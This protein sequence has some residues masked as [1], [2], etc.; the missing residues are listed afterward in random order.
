MA[1]RLP[2]DKF[3]NEILD[4]VMRPAGESLQS[5]AYR[6]NETGERWYEILPNGHRRYHAGRFFFDVGPWGLIEVRV[7]DW[8]S[9]FAQAIHGDTA[10][11]GRFARIRSGKLFP[12]EDEDLIETGE[13]LMHVPTFRSRRKKDF[14]GLWAEAERGE[15]LD[16]S[17]E[18]MKEEGILEAINR[19]DDLGSLLTLAKGEAKGLAMDGIIAALD[20]WLAQAQDIKALDE[21]AKQ[22]VFLTDSN[23]TTKILHFEFVTGQ[24]LKERVF[25]ESHA[26]TR[27]VANGVIGDRVRGEIRRQIDAVLERNGGAGTP[28]AAAGPVDFGVFKGNYE[29]SPQTGGEEGEEDFV[30]SI[31]RGAQKLSDFSFS[32]ANIFAGRPINAFIGGCDFEIDSR[33]TRIGAMGP[34]YKVMIVNYT[35]LRSFLLHSNAVQNLPRYTDAELDKMA[36]DANLAYGNIRQEIQLYLPAEDPGDNAAWETARRAIDLFR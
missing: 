26:I 35:T 30:E 32:T 6:K 16:G 3:E 2:D 5:P 4:L 34:E 8:L 14:G 27:D 25:N 13:L 29:F 9:K 18:R 10:V 21:V 11:W 28:G 12:I 17:L 24:G 22:R 19:G 1:E 36:R 20:V 31:S 33:D 7:G 15:T 23:L